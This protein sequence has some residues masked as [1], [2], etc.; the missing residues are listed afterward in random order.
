[1]NTHLC[2]GVSFAAK[3]KT[4]TAEGWK[5]TEKAFLS[6]LKQKPKQEDAVSALPELSE[7]QLLENV[8]TLLKMG[9]TSPPHDLRRMYIIKGSLENCS[10]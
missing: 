6:T 5:V 7:G 1:M 8:D 3:G 10:I 2:G 9:T 4:V